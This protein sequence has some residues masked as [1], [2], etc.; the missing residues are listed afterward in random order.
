MC[1]GESW[2]IQEVIRRFEEGGGATAPLDRHKKSR[3]YI[4]RFFACNRREGVEFIYL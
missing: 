2:E 3:P 4:L 1:N